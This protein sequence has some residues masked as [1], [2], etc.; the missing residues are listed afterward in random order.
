MTRDDFEKLLADER[1]VWLAAFAASY[2][3]HIH[4]G[5]RDARAKWRAGLDAKA[6]VKAFQEE[7]KS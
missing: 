2:V 1:A 6:A 3:L 5:S 7:C 4:D